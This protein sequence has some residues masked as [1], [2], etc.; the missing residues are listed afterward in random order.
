M[1][2]DMQTCAVYDWNTSDCY[3][4]GTLPFPLPTDALLDHVVVTDANTM[5][6]T[7]YIGDVPTTIT[8]PLE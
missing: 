4:Y 1:A 2:D 8:V 5:Q 3:A 6:L 7:Y